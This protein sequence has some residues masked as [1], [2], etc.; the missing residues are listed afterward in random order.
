ML[1]YTFFFSVADGVNYL[2]VCYMSY[3]SEP[4]NLHPS[5]LV[6]MLSKNFIKTFLVALKKQYSQSGISACLA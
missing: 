4:N 6:E 2:S 5:K 3:I 1:I